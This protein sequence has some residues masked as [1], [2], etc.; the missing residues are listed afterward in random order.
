MKLSVSV[1]GP[2]IKKA[3]G[4]VLPIVRLQQYAVLCELPV[5][6]AAISPVAVWNNP[7][8]VPFISPERSATRARWFAWTIAETT[9]YKTKKTIR[10]GSDDKK[11]K[12]SVIAKNNVYIQD[13][14]QIIQ[15]TAKG[16]FEP[17]STIAKA[18]VP[19]TLRITTEGTFDCSSVISIPEL[20]IRQNLP[21]SGTTD[22]DLGVRP[23]GVLDGTCGMGM[24]PFTIEFK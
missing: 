10:L 15:I 9:P 8:E 14:K 17:A 6:D 5:H 3:L 16:V 20:K 12:L 23:A 22:I 19:T 2:G 18:G 1:P 7:R 4:A 21:S 13:G 24:Y 11:T